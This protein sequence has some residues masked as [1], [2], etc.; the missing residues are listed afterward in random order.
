MSYVGNREMEALAQTHPELYAQLSSMG[1][2]MT[3]NAAQSLGLKDQSQAATTNYLNPSAYRDTSGRIPGGSSRSVGGAGMFGQNN[4][5]AEMTRTAV[6]NDF[7]R[8]QRMKDA[9][10][11]QQITNN[12]MT[13][14][15]N[16]I[17]SM[18]GDMLN[19][20]ETSRSTQD[21]WQRQGGEMVNT[22]VR[23]NTSETRDYTADILRMMGM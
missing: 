1:F 11:D 23:T 6:A 14:K 3:G 13:Q 9:G 2:S 15:L 7:Q 5:R 8:Q 20:K 4:E 21:Q 17:K 18:F 22:P 16:L 12:A 19:R 10:L